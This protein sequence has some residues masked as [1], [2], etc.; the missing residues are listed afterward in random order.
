M[1]AKLLALTGSL[2]AFFGSQQQTRRQLQ[3]VLRRAPV[4]LRLLL[5]VATSAAR[6]HFVL[7]PRWVCPSDLGRI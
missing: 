6:N 4:P 3:L 5:R 1:R 2:R 7:V